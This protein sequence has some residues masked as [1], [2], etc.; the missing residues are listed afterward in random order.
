[1]VYHDAA[2]DI[3]FSLL[4]SGMYGS[5][6][7]ES[8]LPDVIEWNSIFRL[9]KKH[10]VVGII[11][12]SVSLLP[13]RLR[14]SQQTVA[15]MNKF[16]LRILQT[17][18]AMDKTIAR[19][20]SFLRSHHI[21]GVLLKGQ[22]VARYY[23][24]PQ[25]RQSGDIDFYV[26]EKAYKKVIAV[27]KRNL[28]G[29]DEETYSSEQHF[30]FK[31]GGFPVELHRWATRI[32]SPIR[33][34]RFHNWMVHELEHSSRRRTLT[35]DN[36]GITLPSYDFDAV[37]IFYH[38]WRHFISGGIGLRQLC[39][40]TLLFHTHA[41]DIDTD[42]LI[43]NIRRFGITK[44]W[45]LFAC[46][47]VNHLGLNAEK[48]PLYDPAYSEKSDKILHDII[49]G[50]NFGFYTEANIRTPMQGLGWR[51][52]LGKSRNIIGY[53][54]SLFTLIPV[55]ATFLFF[56]RMIFGSIAFTRRSLRHR[57]KT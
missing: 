56:H 45:K 55:E 7:P 10:A 46:I 27:C 24:M 38:A 14:P 49:A 26:G 39:D 33:K 29:P 1:M 21:E 47:A 51:I 48:M 20:V 53:F 54:I 36:V 42:A 6:I 57:K 8:R 11:I 44:G 34:Q 41:D 13:E 5:P 22:G 37:Y 19:L 25:M 30:C 50:G 32:Y 40:W 31:M 23:R 2:I 16:A 43:A 9:A 12:D 3:F 4:R 18:I 35:I 28:I 15:K 17:N 52:A